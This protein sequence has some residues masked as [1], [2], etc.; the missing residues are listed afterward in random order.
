M[1]APGE[2][3]DTGADID[4]HAGTFMPQNGREDALGIGA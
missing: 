4:D 3:C 2:A 1:I